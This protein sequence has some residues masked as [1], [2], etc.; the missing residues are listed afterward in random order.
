MATFPDAVSAAVVFEPFIPNAIVRPLSDGAFAH[1]V[2]ASPLNTVLWWTDP[3]QDAAG[4]KAIDAT[5][6]SFEALLTS[7]GQP[8]SS[9]MLYPNYADADHPVSALYGP[10]L[11]Q[12]VALRESID[13]AGVMLRAGGWK[14]V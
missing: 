7:S 4:L 10:N 8:T 11:P 3:S 6:N 5:A 13:P 2:Y 9:M 14:F 1:S 12:A